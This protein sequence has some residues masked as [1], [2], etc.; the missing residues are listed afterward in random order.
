MDREG[1]GLSSPPERS[2]II[3]V[4]LGCRVGSA[5]DLKQNKE[6]SFEASEPLN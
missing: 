6:T 5:V 3:T 4:V 2:T 1:A